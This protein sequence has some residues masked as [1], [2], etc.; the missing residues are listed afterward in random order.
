MAS[1]ATPAASGLNQQIHDIFANQWPHLAWA[2]HRHNFG[3][4]N[5]TELLNSAH[6]ASSHNPAVRPFIEMLNAAEAR[7]L[8][9]YN[10]N[11]HYKTELG[12]TTAALSNAQ[13]TALQST[14]ESERLRVELQQ[15]RADLQQ[16]RARC[17]QLETRSASTTTEL[18]A[19]LAQ[20]RELHAHITAIQGSL[21]KLQ[22]DHIQTV[23]DLQHQIS[24]LRL[25]HPNP[26]SAT[27]DPIHPN[28][29]RK[30]KDPDPL[31]SG[32]QDKAEKR[33][34]AFETWAAHIDN[35]LLQDGGFFGS[36]RAR[37]LR[38]ASCLTGKAH[39]NIQS[40]LK[41]IYDNPDDPSQWA[42]KTVA[43]LRKELNMR[44]VLVDSAQIAKNRL[45]RFFQHTRDFQGWKADLDDLM[46]QAGLINEQR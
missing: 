33:Q 8:E 2:L 43:D 11:E 21:T 36:D 37:I 27:P 31:F 32:N 19:S 7:L 29:R 42:W 34:A 38:V 1:N 17:Q 23:A 41:S 9:T 44:Y 4:A 12:I 30:T 3:D 26:A 25:N 46:G 24:A 35:V 40:G 20:T 45:D 15:S 5:P 10:D 39:T 14:A 28:I 18:Q 16:A 6:Q 22:S 13:H